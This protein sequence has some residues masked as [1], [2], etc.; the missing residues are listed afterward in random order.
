MDTQWSIQSSC[1]CRVVIDW[2]LFL[3]YKQDAPLWTPSGQFSPHAITNTPSP[4]ISPRQEAYAMRQQ[5][6]SHSAGRS[7]QDAANKV[8]FYSI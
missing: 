4:I 2:C 6:M 1:P 7:P 3:S 5:A 8:L